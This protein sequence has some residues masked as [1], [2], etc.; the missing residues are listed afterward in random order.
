MAVS[1]NFNEAF[2][3]IVRSQRL[4]ELKQ[5]G[6]TLFQG[7]I[8][9]YPKSSTSNLIAPLKEREFEIYFYKYRASQSNDL[10]VGRYVLHWHESKI[11]TNTRAIDSVT[12]PKVIS[13]RYL[14]IIGPLTVHKMVFSTLDI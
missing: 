9:R 6:C 5:T 8:I 1:L 7:L 3:I 10:N 11:S 12:V 14:A 13:H 4:P 2:S